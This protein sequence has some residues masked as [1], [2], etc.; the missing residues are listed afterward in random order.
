[1]L[2]MLDLSID[3]DRVEATKPLHLSIQA[4]A[5]ARQ[6]LADR[7]E[8]V[9][10]NHLD[11]KIVLTRLSNEACHMTGRI[12]ADIVM[13]CII[14]DAEVK[15]SLDIKVDERFAVMNGDD[16]ETVI[17]PMSVQTEPMINR[18][19][20]V[21]ETVAQLILLEAPD[22]PRADDIP[23]VD[24]VVKSENDLGPFGKLADLKK[25]R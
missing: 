6:A 5:E 17:D 20:P 25:T 9:G 21:G 10:I 14:S 1:M 11:G 12:K 4:D 13:T 15:Q 24:I 18:S 16:D 19:I 2:V 3:F 22:W 8:W 23:P 7:F